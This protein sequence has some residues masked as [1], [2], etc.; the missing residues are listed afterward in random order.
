[1][2][3]DLF[4]DVTRP[5]IYIGNRS[6]YT[7]PVSLFS[8]AT[9]VLVITAL[10]LVAPA[11]MPKVFTSSAIPTIVS[12]VPPTPPP[13]PRPPSEVKPVPVENPNAAPV[14]A[15]SEI[16]PEAPQDL[17]WQNEPASVVGGT[18]TGGVDRVVGEPPPAPIER[19]DPVRVGVSVRQPQQI[20]RVEPIYPQIALLARVQG[21]VVIEATIGADGRVINARVL[22]SVSQLD[23]AA[24]D[25]V[26]QWQYTPTLL[27]GVPVPVIMTV[28]VNFQLK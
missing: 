18:V 5:S 14:E 19:Q 22:R 15:P 12:L 28:T 6:K 26:R 4:G 23:Q 27:N 16:K 7:V 11:L 9:I 1:M 25:A 8:H 13:R 2:P 21:L 17:D 3:R 24:L 10:P 20:R